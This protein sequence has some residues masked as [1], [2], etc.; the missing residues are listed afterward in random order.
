MRRR[1]LWRGGM[2]SKKVGL[3]EAEGPVVAGGG[4]VDDAGPPLVQ[5][6]LDPLQVQPVEDVVRVRIRGDLQDILA[7]GLRVVKAHAEGLPENRLHAEERHGR[8]VGAVDLDQGAV[9]AAE[10]LFE[11]GQVATQYVDLSGNPTMDIR[12]NPNG[13]YYAIEG[14]TS[15]NGRVLGKMGH[16]E[17]IGSNVSKNIPIKQNQRIFESGLEY[18]K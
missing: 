11:N 7:D 12:Y 1:R 10:K 2:P 15:P 17:R 5:L 4:E 16:S 3:E 8:S 6:L 14:I 9:L 13:S 18:F